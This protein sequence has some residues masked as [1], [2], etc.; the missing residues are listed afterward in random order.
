MITTKEKQLI[1]DESIQRME[2]LNTLPKTKITGTRPSR[3]DF[4]TTRIGAN[5][6]NFPHWSQTVPTAE[7][8]DTTQGH[9]DRDKT[10]TEQ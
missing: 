4:A 2:R 9:A 8:K 7:K 3:A 5:C 10:T 1:K 6:M